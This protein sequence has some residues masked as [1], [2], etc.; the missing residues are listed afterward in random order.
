[1]SGCQGRIQEKL[2]TNIIVAIAL[3]FVI[4]TIAIRVCL[5]NKSKNNYR[6]VIIDTLTVIGRNDRHF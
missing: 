5:P 6:G 2:I 3:A 1:M 4:L